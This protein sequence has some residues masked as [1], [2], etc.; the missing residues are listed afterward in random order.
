MG[1]FSR[2][3][4]A[5]LA[6]S[7]A[8]HYFSV[9]M[10]QG[11]PVVDVDL[12]E[13]EDLRR[14]EFEDLNNA[15][16][17]DGVLFGSDGF[18]IV[19]IANGGINTVVLKAKS[20]G[21]KL[22]SLRIDLGASTAAS[23]LGFDNKNFTSKRFGSS[24]AQLTTNTAE[25]F[26]L[27]NGS[28][29][30]VAANDAPPETITFVSGDFANIAAATAAEVAAVI[31]TA[32]N[33]SA[34]P[35]TGNDFIIK[36]GDGTAANAGRILVEGQMAINESDLKYT[37]QPL[38]NNTPL[39]GLWGVDVL[40]ALTTPGVS[41][42]Q[43]AFLDVWDREVD[44]NED[45]ELVDTRIGVETAI[46]L[47]REWVVRIIKAADFAAAV[48]ARP[49][50]HS[51]Y[52]LAQINR[53]AKPE[54]LEPMISDERDTDL[55]LRRE[56]AYRAIDGTVLVN[57]NQ[58]L[59]R[60]LE[61]RDNVRDFIQFLTAKFVKP[62]S[63]Y[64]AGEVAGIEALSAIA[65]VADHGI[66][67]LNAKSLTTKDAITFFDQL[68]QAEQRFVSVWETAVLPIVKQTG[69][70][71]DTAFKSTIA[72]IKLFLTG[73]APVG[74]LALATALQQKNL[75]EAVRTQGQIN[76]LFASEADKPIG[77]LLL[78]YLG[79]TTPTIEKNTSFDLRYRV[80]GTV[81]PADPLQ[82][83][84]FMN[85]GWKSTVKNTDN[86]PFKVTFGPGNDSEEF[87]VSVLPPN[88]AA[89]NTPITV[90]VSAVHNPSGLT[91]SSTPKTLAIGSAPPS[92][93]QDFAI[94]VATANV[95]LVG[96]SFQVPVNLASAD[97]KFKVS[98]NTNNP[99]PVLL[100]FDPKAAP[101]WNIVRDPSFPLDGEITALGS[102]LCLFQFDPPNTV[103]Q[104][105]TFTFRAKNSKTNAPLG[106]VQIKLLTVA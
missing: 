56:I 38:F 51:Y 24:P 66:A 40:P 65:N 20:T 98:N 44:S 84:V 41:E 3:P 101:G 90:R 23:K 77:T 28:T 63:A 48:A 94:T 59:S 86:S 87:I 25:P 70:I 33:L 12:N 31:T 64:V 10:Q 7:R 82:V 62:D 4:K 76:A 46:R 37:E 54:I 78:T 68:F 73:P 102:R 74:F 81:T 1:N 71:Y 17:G 34:Q 19:P 106:E 104:S 88:V 32:V 75:F 2:D 89:A 45:P 27:V 83:E 30:V 18:R 8:K 58:F 22:S 80:T 93:E 29:L 69:K 39:A 26:N 16:I 36:G 79:S 13:L 9:R 50:G 96:D 97:I 57:S 99:V 15:V 35:G 55:S 100:E 47:R 92:S 49:A 60:L 105:L 91:H 103:G 85:A 72:Q 53:S 21:V 14:L 6:D 67:L 42:N 5:R 95:N 52:Q 61:T 11:V 43:V